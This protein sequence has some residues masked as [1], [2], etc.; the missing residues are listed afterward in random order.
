MAPYAPRLRDDWETGN[1]NLQMRSSSIAQIMSH[2]RAS[3]V[4]GVFEIYTG[5]KSRIQMLAA[6]TDHVLHLI[7]ACFISKSFLES[8]SESCSIIFIFTKG[9]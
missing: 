4:P 9:C 2:N 8:F 1:R 6:I 7:P 5:T 3:L